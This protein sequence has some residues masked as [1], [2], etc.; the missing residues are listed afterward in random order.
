VAVTEERDPGADRRA[1]AGWCGRA[2]RPRPHRRPRLGPR[3]SVGGGPRRPWT[4]GCSFCSSTW[5]GSSSTPAPDGSPRGPGGGGGPGPA[6]ARG[7]RKVG[8]G[9]WA[10]SSLEHRAV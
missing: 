7:V 2:D 3:T 4:T 5:P 9:L 1:S 8:R 10:A 6:A